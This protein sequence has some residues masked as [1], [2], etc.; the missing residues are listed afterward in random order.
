MDSSTSFPALDRLSTQ[1]DFFRTDPENTATALAQAVDEAAREIAGWDAT[2]SENPHLARTLDLSRQLWSA[3]FH[4]RAAA[5]ER[6]ALAAE[7]SAADWPGQLAALMVAPAW[8]W[9]SAPTLEAAAPALWAHYVEWKLSAPGRHVSATQLDHHVARLEEMAE[10]LDRAAGANL[11]APGVKDAV[12]TFVRLSVTT[13]PLRSQRSLRRWMKARIALVR[14][15]LRHRLDRALAPRALPRSGR[16]LTVGVLVKEWGESLGARARFAWLAGL[17]PEEFAVTVYCEKPTSDGLAQEL[18]KNVAR[19]QALPRTLIDRLDTLRG[20]NLDVLIHTGAFDQSADLSLALQR[21]APLQIAFGDCAWATGLPEIDLH[22]VPGNATLDEFSN[23]V[24]LLRGSGLAWDADIVAPALETISRSQ[25]GLSEEGPIFVSASPLEA[26]SAEALVAWGELL[27]STENSSLLLLPP[28]GTDTF[29]LEQV[30]A[31]FH[32]EAGIDSSRVA[33]SIGDPR[34]GFVHGSVYLDTFPLSAPVPV[35]AALAARLPVVTWEG[36]TLRAR[37]GS[38]ALRAAGHAEWIATDAE[39]YL[40]L[41]RRAL[42]EGRPAEAVHI[43]GVDLAASAAD[44]GTLMLLA[45]DRL[46]EGRRLPAVVRPERSTVVVDEEVAAARDALGQQ[47]FRGA[48]RHARIALAQDATR[49]D[50]CGILSRA[51]LRSGHVAAAEYCA[52]VGLRGR[53]QEAERWIEVGQVLRVKKEFPGAISAFETAL[54]IEPRSIDGWLGIAELAQLKGA[55]DLAADAV[56]MARRIN[57]HDPRLVAL[58][59]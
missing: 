7:L 37:G 23:S 55:G 29:E 39:S 50:A 10:M 26:L 15:S 27:R 46:A 31:R 25:F 53:E 22:I 40:Q 48:V 57:P 36:P 6:L 17:P 30:L 19:M 4:S 12:D 11:S 41:A 16:A 35:Q 18:K 43:S 9:E 56:G 34:A 51:H 42:A 45:F 2:A 24:G 28:T 59:A 5:K 21:V 47:D 58:G 13:L 20:A 1:L 54:R 33:V 38:N 52:F 8:Q 3:G 14:K 49:S 32:T 44:L